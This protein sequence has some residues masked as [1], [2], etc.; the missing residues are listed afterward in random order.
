MDIALVSEVLVV[1]G[2]P[3][4]MIEMVH[5]VNAG[6]AYRSQ[7][8]GSGFLTSSM[9]NPGLPKSHMYRRRVLDMASTDV[10]DRMVHFFHSIWK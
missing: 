8:F 4:G 2:A 10:E 9:G 5:P 1:F 6:V 3:A 7:Q